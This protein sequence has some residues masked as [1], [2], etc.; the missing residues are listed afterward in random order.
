MPIVID[1]LV[2]T[3]EVHDEREMRRLVREEI[4]RRLREERRSPIASP[5]RADPTDPLAGQR[6]R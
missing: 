4:D 6:E 2:T 3:L 1:E 5:T